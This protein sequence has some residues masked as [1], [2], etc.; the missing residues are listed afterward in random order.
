MQEMSSLAG[1]ELLMGPGPA[2]VKSWTTFSLSSPLILA[3]VLRAPRFDQEDLQLH[4]SCMLHPQLDITKLSPARWLATVK[5]D[6]SNGNWPA[7]NSL[8]DY[9]FSLQAKSI[10]IEICAINKTL[11]LI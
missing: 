4:M 8:L 9:F 11:Q 3:N 7:F 1:D 5:N 6:F 10:Y 2:A